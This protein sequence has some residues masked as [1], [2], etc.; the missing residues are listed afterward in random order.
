LAAIYG[1]TGQS[2]YAAGDLLV[3]AAGNTLNKLSLGTDGKVLQSNGT[4]VIYAD[5][6]G[7]T[8]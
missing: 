1:G 7:G 8:F 4:A 3:G 5:L 2:T 6:D